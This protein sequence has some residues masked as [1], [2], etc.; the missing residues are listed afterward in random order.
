M[1]AKMPFPGDN[2]FVLKW[3]LVVKDTAFSWEVLYK[4]IHEYLKE[5]G[6]QDL[7]IDEDMYETYYVDTDIGGGAK[8][9]TIWFRA[10]KDPFVSGNGYLH[11]FFKLDIQVLVLKTKEVMHKGQKIKLNTGEF[12]FK[13]KFWYEEEQDKNNMWNTNKILA[14][15]KKLFWTRLHQ[16]PIKATKGELLKYS[17][18]IYSYIQMYTGMTPQ[19][20]AKEYFSSIKGTEQ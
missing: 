5:K 2:K 3:E 19:S 16:T 1:P 18:E 17:N 13:A 12:T 4:W 14:Y 11:L 10:H 7:Q 8:N 20:G 6:W 15:F 9:Q